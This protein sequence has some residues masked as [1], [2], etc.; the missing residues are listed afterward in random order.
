MGWGMRLP[1]PVLRSRS[2]PGKWESKRIHVGIGLQKWRL[3]PPGPEDLQTCVLWLWDPGPAIQPPWL[4]V[5]IGSSSHN[6]LMLIWNCHIT[7]VPS[8]GRCP[9]AHSLKCLSVITALFVFPPNTHQNS[10]YLGIF[11]CLLW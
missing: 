11:W 5:S 9:G 10:N 7:P 8:L 4:L 6:L 2:L 3:R 1:Y